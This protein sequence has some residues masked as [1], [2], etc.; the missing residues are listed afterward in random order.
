MK[1]IRT[2]VLFCALAALIVVLLSC[3]VEDNQQSSTQK[4]QEITAA[5]AK[6]MIEQNKDNPDFM[7][8]DVRSEGEFSGGHIPGAI[9]LLYTAPDFTDKMKQNG[10]EKTYLIYCLSGGRSASAIKKLLPLGFTHL[11]NLD[12]GIMDWENEGY[13]VVLQ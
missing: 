1:K 9:N 6:T 7:I 8:I 12:G 5:E 11:Y 10:K 2:Y 3:N 13:E 4:F